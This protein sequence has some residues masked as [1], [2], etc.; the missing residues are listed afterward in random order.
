[1][2]VGSEFAKKST[3]SA[4]YSALPPRTNGFAPMSYFPS[5]FPVRLHL[6]SDLHLARKA[7]HMFM[8][9]TIAFIYLSG[10]SVS[11]AVTILGTVLG[12]D[13][14]METARLRIPSLNEKIMRIWGPF[15]RSCEVDRMSGI[16]YYL[17]AMIL[18]IAIFPKP[19]AILSILYLACGDPIASLFGILYGHKSYRLASGKSLVGTAAGI[20]TCALV[21]F[22]FLKTVPVSDTSLYVLTLVGGI[23]GGMAELVPLDMD[24]NFTIPVMSGFVLWLAF[25]V[26]GI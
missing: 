17:A 8:G 19:V 18:A 10:M 1:M 3:T 7:W 5:T 6:R 20:A 15:M 14:I 16:S 12:F 24:D 4:Q 26:L 25:I 21:T 13:L 22:I 9:C 2:R 23:A 11:L